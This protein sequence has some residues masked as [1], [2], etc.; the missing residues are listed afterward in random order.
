MTFPRSRVILLKAAALNVIPQMTL[1]IVSDSA[2]CFFVDQVERGDDQ[3]LKTMSA[4]EQNMR[5]FS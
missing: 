1:S 3:G 2:F 5:T 4:A